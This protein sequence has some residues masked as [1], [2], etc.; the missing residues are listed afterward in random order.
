MK[1]T[2]I[3]CLSTVLLAV[4][5]LPSI[6]ADAAPALK[7]GQWRPVPVSNTGHPASLFEGVAASAANDVWQV[8]YNIDKHGRTRNYTTLTEHW[9]GTKWSLVPSVNPTNTADTLLAVTT[10]TANDA[11]AV[12]HSGVKCI[13]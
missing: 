8:G 10:V 4:L 9:N 11:W 5:A 1:R 6:G 12:G 2:L 7:C 13:D 3:F